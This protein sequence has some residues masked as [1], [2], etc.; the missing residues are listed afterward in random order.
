MN[1][2]VFEIFSWNRPF[3][4]DLK[5]FLL[6]ITDKQPGKAVII[7]PNRRPARYLTHLLALDKKAGILPRFVTIG[8]L[9]TAWRAANTPAPMRVANL[10]DQAALL[11]E[12]VLE[13]AETNE[14][15]ARHFGQMNIG[16]FLPW[17][18]RLSQVLEDFNIAGRPLENLANLEG[19]LSQPAATL[20]AS[21]R[22]LGDSFT[23]KLAERQW[24]TNGYD[25]LLATQY[26]ENIP[27]IFKPAPERPVVIAGFYMPDYAHGVLL[28]R[29]WE[30]GAHVC[31]HTD[32]A[33]AEGK[34]GHPAVV[35]H[36][37]WLKRWGAQPRLY[38]SDQ[39]EI[40][41]RSNKFF[42]GYDLHS[43]LEQVNGIL[44]E[45]SGKSTAIILGKP[46]ALL[47]TL[48]NLPPLNVNVSM[49]YP[50]ERSPLAQLIEDLLSLGENRKDGESFGAD[51]V[52]KVLR[53]PFLSMAKVEVEGKK[54]S[55]A[56]YLRQLDYIIRKT[57]R[58]W[59]PKDTVKAEAEPARR[60]LE[61]L[62]ALFTSAENL[63]EMGRAMKGL[64]RWL[65]DHAGKPWAMRFPL[66]AE[67]LY[68]LENEIAPALSNNLLARE[69]LSPQII[70]DI[71]LNL[72]GQQRLPF[73][74][75]PI[76]GVQ[77][78]GLLESRLLHFD[79]LIFMDATDDVL[80]GVSGV[81][82]LLP[83]SL[84]YLLNLPDNSK[85]EAL[86]Y[87]NMRRL[88]ESA[89][90]AHFLWQEGI[91]GTGEGKKTRSR[92]M[93]RLIW[94]LEKKDPE[95]VKNSA[96]PVDRPKTRLQT[97]L[98][99]GR[100][101]AA[102]EK[103]KSA[104]NTFWQGPV[105]PSA[106]DGYLACPAQ[107]IRAHAL[108]LSEDNR[109]SANV[110]LVTGNL[111]HAILNDV[112]E[113]ANHNEVREADDRELFTGRV[114]ESFEK[115]AQRE[116]LEDKIPIDTFLALEETIPRHLWEYRKKQPR[117]TFIV[118]LETRMTATLPVNGKDISFTGK[119]DRLDQRNGSLYLLDYKTG[120]PQ[121]ANSLFWDNDEFF[122][123]ARMA[124]ESNDFN[125]VD[126]QFQEMRSELE[127]IQLPLYLLLLTKSGFTEKWGPAA[128]AAW[129]YLA[130][131]GE[132]ENIFSSDLSGP[133]DKRLEN[134]LVAIELIEAH[135]RLAPEFGPDD[136][137]KCDRCSYGAM[138]RN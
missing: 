11:H 49:G 3:L 94:E 112:Y 6:E 21:L 125:L 133:D 10:L 5:N 136:N 70:R 42:S 82:P 12:C 67:A 98:K 81:D 2:R 28:K 24:T 114:R 95:L 18:I 134:C 50:M 96:S 120:A 41:K 51:N 71:V 66:D 29:L 86:A 118:A 110:N 79:R 63:A 72:I 91:G 9:V 85:R 19:E 37:K 40:K 78:M 69:K 90:E 124:I 107:F 106:L 111:V 31:L 104:I 131:S 75:D 64:T 44:S 58:Y 123:K 113:P 93:E 89:E 33:L 105:S 53:H 74:A 92:F 138:C 137:A 84:R 103:L 4:P 52:L 68:R 47:A 27:H 88:L 57:G 62:A 97:R 76:E 56:P 14:L 77:V 54:L 130:G 46:E 48:Q 99:T 39:Q 55:L 121:K 87:H 127:S 135:M 116:K 83:D 60:E 119:F 73:E 117:E 102:T 16:A 101:I 35:W 132:E 15:L 20:L 115:I 13:A 38:A 100:L 32:P 36:G 129:V 25:H 126:Q 122:E 43:Q 8:E 45:D 22:Q 7:T 26:V 17:A 30:E 80:P 34:K 109:E 1:K 61:F 128:N 23:E 108:C 65:V 59:R